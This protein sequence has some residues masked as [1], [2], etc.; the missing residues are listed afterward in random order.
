MPALIVYIALLGLGRSDRA[1]IILHAQ[2]SEG[3]DLHLSE[4]HLP[5]D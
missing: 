5:T 2:L 1:K 3:Q 4:I